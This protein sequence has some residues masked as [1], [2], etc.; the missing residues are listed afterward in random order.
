MQEKNEGEALNRI[1]KRNR[2]QFLDAKNQKKGCFDKKD[3]CLFCERTFLSTSFMRHMEYQHPS[4]KEVVELNLLPKRSEKR[5]KFAQVLR[6]R[7]NYLHN[8]KVV[9]FGGELIPAQ[10]PKTTKTVT[11]QLHLYVVCAACFGL[12]SKGEMWRH[13]C[14]ASQK[15]PCRKIEMS[16]LSND[17]MSKEVKIFFNRLKLDAIGMIARKDHLIWKFISKKVLHKGMNNFRVISEQVR[18]LC[19]FLAEARRDFGSSLTFTELLQ[20]Q[21]LEAMKNIVLRMFQYEFKENIETRCLSV[22]RPSSLKRLG[23]ALKRLTNVLY[24]EH[25]KRSSY[26]SAKEIKTLLRL[27]DQEMEP[28]MA[29]A[30]KA[31]ASSESGRPQPLPSS[32]HMQ[33]LKTHLRNTIKNTE[34]CDSNLRHL[35]ETVLAYLILFNKRR[36]SE[37][38]NLTVNS[39]VEKEKFKRNALEEARKLTESEIQ[40]LK[41]VELVYVVGKCKRFVPI[42]FA[43][44]VV[45]LVDWFALKANTYI[46]ANNND[47]PMRGHDAMRVVSRAAG[48][49]PNIMTSTKFRKLA[50][51]TLQVN[52]RILY[53]PCIAFRYSVCILSLSIS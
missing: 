13:A 46:F 20:P 1:A 11:D 6:N 12:Y 32:D 50:A 14:P 19:Y 31:L 8:L 26:T 9:K 36:S 49:P 25:L 30:Q 24:F 45:D 15:R 42:I 21:N 3:S 23:Q 48:I 34:K 16:D 47:R 4:E 43:E 40:L 41:S 2:L 33:Q 17:K 44:E 52:I 18:I 39:W 35:K 22:S 7:G 27:F 5:R 29:N 51:T 37:V 53:K 10:R 28:L 38:A